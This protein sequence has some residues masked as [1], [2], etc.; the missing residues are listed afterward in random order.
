MAGGWLV[1][2]AL[3][4]VACST[5]YSTCLYVKSACACIQQAHHHYELL[6]CL[7]SPRRSAVIGSDPE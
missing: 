3:A 7:K 4:G 2:V 1:G 6:E 5:A